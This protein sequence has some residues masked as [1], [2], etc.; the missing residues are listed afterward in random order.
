MA[1]S[2]D[3]EKF[4]RRND[5]VA[6]Y[7]EQRREGAGLPSQ[8][9][10]RRTATKKPGDTNDSGEEIAVTRWPKPHRCDPLAAPAILQR[11][12]AISIPIVS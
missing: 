4:E 9:P 7:T 10:S 2:E 12:T 6:D 11:G 1:H 3:R 8:R 5:R